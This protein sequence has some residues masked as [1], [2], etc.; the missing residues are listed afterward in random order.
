MTRGFARSTIV[1]AALVVAT[2]STAALAAP[3]SHEQDAF[4]DHEIAASHDEVAAPSIAHQHDTHDHAA[5]TPH[6]GHGPRD[7]DAVW[8]AATPA[9][10]AGATRLINSTET[11]V[12]RYRDVDAAI[13]DGFRPNPHQ[14]GRLVHYPN[15]R[16]RRDDN[17]LDP[18]R[19]EGL[20]YS[21]G[22]DGTMRLVAALY[23]V[24]GGGNPPAPGGDIT[25]WHSHTPGCAHPAD[26]QGCE[27]QVRMYMLHVWLFDGAK[28]PFADSFAAARRAS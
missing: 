12:A 17:V 14:Q 3:A 7:F 6:T 28:D 10:R 24:G 27:A 20:V 23:T 16:N 9:E 21:R 2:A 1:A 19:L 11:A 26:E 22:D 4:H 25:A 15:A 5:A 18:N 13:A 8:D